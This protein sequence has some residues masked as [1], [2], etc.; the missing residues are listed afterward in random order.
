MAA[1]YS[2]SAGGDAGELG[3]AYGLTPDPW[4]Q[5]VLDDWLAVGGNGRLASGVCGVF[6]PRQNG[7]NAILEIVELFKATIQGRRILHTAHELKS[8][9]KAFMRLR[10]FFENER[11]F[12]DLYFVAR[13]RGS[14][15]G[16]TVDDLVCDEAQE[17]SDEQLEA[18]LPTVSAAPSGDPQQIFLGT[19]P[20]PLADGSV[21][22]R[23]RGQALSGG[24]RFAWTE[25]SI[26][27]ESDPDDVSRQWRKLAGDTNPALGRRLN[28][29][30]VSDEHESMSAAGFARE[31]L[32]WWDRGQSASSVIPADKWVQSAVGEAALVGGKVFGVSFSRSGDRVALAGAGRTD[33]G[34]HVE[35]IDGLSGTIVDGVGQLADWLALRWGDTEK[36]MVAGSGA[37]LLQKALTDRGVPGRGV[38]VADTGTYVE[39]C[40]A[41]LEGVRSGV[42][43]HPR[44]D[45]RRDMLD[46]A[47]RSAVQKKKGSAWGW[48]SSFKDGSE[49]PLEAVSLAYLGAKMA[50]ARRRERSGRKRVSVV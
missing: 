11:Q 1:A 47:V 40:Q 26:P 23:L 37:V 31:R 22:L 48:G 7:K 34:V 46:I 39:A 13:S 17:L 3:R 27:D 9:R 42:V 29:G 20:G 12:P 33:A 36:I 21:V 18:L 49:V 50:K 6:V 24:K 19:P 16:F 35:V 4:Q 2:V 41:F 25:F 15:R 44:A 43:S 5:Q 14:A 32:G 8:A 10:S 38:V 45:S 28:F 30:T